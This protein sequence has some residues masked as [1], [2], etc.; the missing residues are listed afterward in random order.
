MSLLSSGFDP[1]ELFSSGG[2]N[3][4]DA[5]SDNGPPIPGPYNMHS[6]S[7]IPEQELEYTDPELSVSPGN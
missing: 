5:F 7:P 2:S 3:P 6:F 1:Q 4:D